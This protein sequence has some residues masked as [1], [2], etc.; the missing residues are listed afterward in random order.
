MSFP[1][2]TERQQCWDNRDAFW[3]C[4]DT[5]APE[6]SLESG[7]KFPRNALNRKLFEKSC[8]GQWVKHFDRKRSYDQFKAKMASGFDP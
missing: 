3:K 6:Y 8:P 2:K 7:I 5:K 1:S 4:L